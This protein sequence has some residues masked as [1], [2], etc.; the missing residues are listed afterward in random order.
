M[1]T[2]PKIFISFLI[3]VVLLVITAVNLSSTDQTGEHDEV[4]SSYHE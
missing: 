3:I 2:A 4:L 1:K